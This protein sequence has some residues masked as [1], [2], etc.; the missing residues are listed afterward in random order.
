MLDQKIYHD[1][2]CPGT[3]IAVDE[4]VESFKDRYNVI[5]TLENVLGARPNSLLEGN[6]FIIQKI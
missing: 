3:K 1:Y 6:D 4:I 2:G 5:G